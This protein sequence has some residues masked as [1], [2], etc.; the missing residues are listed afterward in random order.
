GERLAILHSGLSE[1]ERAQE[2]ERARS[3]SARVVLGPRSAVFAP[4]ERLGV[5]VVDE[6]HDSAFKQE[7]SPRYH[8]RDLA[9]MRAHEAGAVAILASATPSF[10]TRHNAS[11]GKLTV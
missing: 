8:A 10:E 6:E 5:V 2:W 4:V 11:L 3:G 7:H 1:G 9:L